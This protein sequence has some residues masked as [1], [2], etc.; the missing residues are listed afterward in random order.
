MKDKELI[1]ENELDSNIILS[2]NWNIKNSIRYGGVCIYNI[3]TN[4]FSL[5][6]YIENDYFTILE[7]ILIQTRPKN[8]LYLPNSDPIDDKRIKLVTNLCDI[9]TEPLTKN[10][11]TC[12]FIENDL[13]K[14]LKDSDVKNHIHF[15]DLQIACKSLNSIIKYLS[16]LN[17][18][19]AINKC[20]IK[21]YNIN[22]YLKLDK[23]AITAL[24]IFP[25]QS[26]DKKGTSSSSGN[27][28]TLYSFLNKCKTKIGE[29][30]LLTWVT[31]P[32]TD[33]EKINERLDMVE[34]LKED[35]VT[36]SIIQ[37]DY[38]RK[39]SDL[40][41]I[42]K[43]LKCVDNI[44]AMQTK[45][46]SKETTNTA[47]GNISKKGKGCTL[48]DLIKIY[49]CVI[50]AK[51]ILYCLNDYNG[52]HR[53]TLDRLILEPLKNTV[54][55]FN[56]F[57]KLI[58][59]TIDF[60]E[61]ENNNFL[62]S[63][64]FDETLDKLADQKDKTMNAIKEHKLEVEEDISQMK[65]SKKSGTKEDI[66][67]VD[68]NTNLF[69]FRAVK[70]DI[71]LIQQRKKVY[72]TVRMNKNEILFNTNK[73]KDLC[74][75]Y[76]SILH[77][78]NIVQKEL[79]DKAI[80]VA[81][82]YWEQV[83]TLSD[84]LS[85]IDV[86]CAFAFVT[87]SCISSYVRPILEKNGEVLEMKSSRHPLI[88]SNLLLKNFIPN[89][90][91]MNKEDKR[92]NIITGPNMGGKS[93]YIRQIALICFM[94]HIGCFV[95]CSYARLPI[96]SQIMCR[97][98]SSD[99]QLKG[100]STFFSEMIEMAAIIKN[101]DKNTLVIIDELGRGTSTYEGFGI[102][103]SIAHYILNSIQCFC[104]FA[105]HFHEM[106][107]LE[108]EYKGVINN[109]V[110]A[111]VD[112]DKRK[113]SFLYEIKKGYAD[114]SYGV[115]VA[116]IAKLPPDVIDKAFEK[117]KELESVENRHYFKK[118]LKTSNEQDKEDNLCSQYESNLKNIFAATEEA[119]F[120][121]NINKYQDNLQGMLKSF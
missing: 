72:F 51:K 3:D 98:G 64:K 59:L 73:L 15:L 110:A 75:R 105:T 18:D 77:D 96:F 97:V 57:L 34:I 102:S 2:I 54:S 9:K 8:F 85:S 30:K 13:N 112:T 87:S 71:N 88:E 66:R 12:S 28:I 83:E 7:S 63:R 67:L 109:H 21:N 94:A 16:L 47:T 33:V 115:H 80:S 78:Y 46:K 68:C 101:A 31:H 6:E 82:T 26:D 53:Q 104:L 74:K 117:S 69:L 25:N 4:E 20:S 42:G 36:R 38:L 41:L 14:L 107:N 90:I 118:K 79:A 119:E 84:L 43:R 65:G 24:N 99:I 22:A 92:L 61:I 40:H 11:Y 113:I 58:E 1:N 103:W 62:I 35:S 49:D 91:S 120:L 108:D 39:I 17:D 86:F 95:P 60:D 27:H 114:K 48:E 29:R 76:E 5:C 23:A 44:G 111:K 100:I 116:Q 55:G 93:T 32:L 50:V 45:G 19:V 89:D 52:K 81:S 37:S 70:K 106:S 56:S 121:S 10:D